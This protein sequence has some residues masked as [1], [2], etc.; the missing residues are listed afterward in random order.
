VKVFFI[1]FALVVAVLAVYPFLQ[2]SEHGEPLTGLPWQVEIQSDGS[3]QVFGIHIGSSRLLDAVSVLG[4]NMEVA[5][6]AA[7]DETGSLEMY[8]GQYHAGLLS[9]KLVLHTDVSETDI[10]QWRETAVKSEYMASGTAR[11]YKLSKQAL[12]Q[13]FNEVI[14]GITFIPAVNLDEE[15]IVSR[16]GMPDKQLQSGGAMH[17]LYPEI[18]LDITLH[19]DMKEVLQYVSPQAF[20]QLTAP[21]E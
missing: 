21:L 12:E 11:K 9:G 1:V 6:V 18:G 4:D 15:V 3:T 19:K 8:Y 2:Q 7:T 10:S 14:T 5:I 16:F 17:Y 13:A 20:Q